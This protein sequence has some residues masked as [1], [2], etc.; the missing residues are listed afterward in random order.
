MQTNDYIIK[1]IKALSASDKVSKAKKLFTE[2]TYTHLPIVDKGFLLGL[3][4]E[5]DIQTIEDDDKLIK[6]FSF[7]FHLF[8]ADKKTNWFELLKV[9]ALNDSNIIPVLDEN[10]KYL[11]YYEL[12][13]ILH[14]F[15]STPFLNDTG[16]ILVVSKDISEYSFSEISQII[17][18][19][20][21]TLL[22]AFISKIHDDIVEVTVKLSDHDLN[23]TIQTF[24]RYDYNIL[25]GFHMDEYLN[26]LKERSEYLQKYLNI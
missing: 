1:D 9:F 13:D 5:A 2:L 4:A 25:T 8:F 14:L 26:T 17:E 22:G 6:E 24:R 18:S 19:N 10:Q 16:A 20:N 12:T 11:G 3:V 7:V 21:A 23:N 15:N